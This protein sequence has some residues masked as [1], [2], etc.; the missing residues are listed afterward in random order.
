VPDVGP[1]IATKIH[2]FFH[3]PKQVSL[4]ARLRERGVQWEESPVETAGALPLSGWT[5]VLTGAL[6]SLSR[7]EAA[8]LLRALGAKIAGSV[9]AKTKLVVVGADAGSK[10]AKARALG[11]AQIGEAGLQALLNTPK[12]AEQ[13]IL[14]HSVAAD[15]E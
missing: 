6:E 8:D 15:N 3:D 5:V 14:R 12:A 4:I 13:I 11:I 7:D 9:S 1:T 10:A 2:E